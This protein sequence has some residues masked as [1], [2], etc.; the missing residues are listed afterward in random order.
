MTCSLVSSA[1]KVCIDAIPIPP[2]TNEMGRFPTAF[3]SLMQAYG[4]GDLF[5]VVSY[6]AGACSEAHGALVVENYRHYLFELKGSQPTLLNE[7]R[8]LLGGLCP[9]R[10]RPRP[11]TW[12]RTGGR[13]EA[14]VPDGRD[15]RL[16]RLDAP[17]D[18]GASRV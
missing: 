17:G 18:G 11:S 1:A 15:G 14:A 3:K 8:S 6:D 10:R 13:D 2:S 12:S 4:K 5:K 16:P 7:A 9:S